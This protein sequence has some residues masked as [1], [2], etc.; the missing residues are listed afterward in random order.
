MKRFRQ[1][2]SQLDRAVNLSNLRVH[3]TEYDTR[4]DRQ[5]RQNDIH[6]GLDMFSGCSAG[7][8]LGLLLFA[9]TKHRLPL[10]DEIVKS[11][12]D[13][14]HQNEQSQSPQRCQFAVSC[15]QEFCI[16]PAPL[17]DTSVLVSERSRLKAGF[18]TDR[19]I[20]GDCAS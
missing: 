9:E 18:K 2:L 1:F 4:H 12:Q 17:T 5:C 20:S 14:K 7:S 15:S 10:H 13:D 8:F 6:C 16:K 11:R 19:E 3:R